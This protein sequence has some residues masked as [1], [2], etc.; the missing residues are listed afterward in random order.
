MTAQE[1][2][3][4]ALKA[5]RRKRIHSFRGNIGC[6]W[7][8]ADVLQVVEESPDVAWNTHDPFGHML[9]VQM[10]NGSYI[11]FQVARLE[12]GT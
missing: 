10:E 1:E 2:A 6:D 9:C 11:R 12:V 5:I 7:D 3:L 4:R 8:R